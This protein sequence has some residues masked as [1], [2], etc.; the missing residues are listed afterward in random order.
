[1]T[2]CRGL[3]AVQSIAALLTRSPRQLG[4][5][6][7]EKRSFSARRVTKTPQ[8]IAPANSNG[9]YKAHVSINYN[10]CDN[11]S[12]LI[13]GTSTSSSVSEYGFPF[14]IFPYRSIAFRLLTSIFESFI[15]LNFYSCNAFI[16][17]YNNCNSWMLFIELCISGNLVT[18]RGRVDN[19]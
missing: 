19:G 18:E 13:I 17:T 9:G 11:I 5:R 10:V 8:S 14:S 4:V 1:M 12:H 3:V 2:R 15:T 6:R 7:N 16:I